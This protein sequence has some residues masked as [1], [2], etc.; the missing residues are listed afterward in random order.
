MKHFLMKHFL[1]KHFLMKHFLMKHF[2]MKHSIN[3]MSCTVLTDPTKVV[4]LCRVSFVC[5][6]EKIPF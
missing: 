4:C 3:K 5:A 2:P 6:S 1:M